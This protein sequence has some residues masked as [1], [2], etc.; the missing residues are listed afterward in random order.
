[1]SE[2]SLLP[3]SLKQA[4]LSELSADHSG[5]LR[6]G[7]VSAAQIAQDFGTPAYVYDAAILRR[8]LERVAAALGP[9]VSILFA[10]KANPNAA[11]ARTLRLA[12]AGA[13]VA[14]A[15]EIHVASHAGFDG[16]QIQFAGPGKDER[17]LEL[18]IRHR[19]YC[20]NVESEGEYEAVASTA[21]RL[22]E[23]PAVSFRLNPKDGLCG[24]RMHMGGGSK[25]FGLDATAIVQLVRRVKAE[26]VCEFRGLHV[27]AGT[28]SF[29]AAAWVDNAR[30]L[31]AFAAELERETG[32]TVHSLDFG[33]GFGVPLFDGD[34][35]LDLAMLGESLQALIAQDARPERRYFVELGRYLAATAGVYLT[36]VLYKKESAGRTHLILDGGMHHHAAAAGVGSVIRRPYPIVA[37][38]APQAEV[39]SP[40][41]LGGP[42][43]TPADEL[44]VNLELPELQPGALVAVLA[45]GA[46]GLTFSNVMFLSHPTP[47][48]VLVDD[49]AAHLVREAGRVED[50]MRGQIVPM[51]GMS[52]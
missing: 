13:E 44:A 12:G 30:G 39:T 37:V 23:R 19:L 4:L 11:V 15:G 42:L 48:E 18:A 28:Q 16:Q 31:V 5:G 52:R 3:V 47:C 35:S 49:G 46:Y 6:V 50:S 10:L 22:G 21:R 7:S 43:C 24:S 45:S 33:G 17:D 36:R 38:H 8:N 34:K 26:N 9:R 20:I 27:Y 41:T 14:S 2:E 25:K 32:Q 1:M 29:D 40:Y 51:T